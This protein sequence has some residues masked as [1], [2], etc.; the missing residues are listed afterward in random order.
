MVIKLTGVYLN[1]KWVPAIKLSDSKTKHTGDI[2]TIELCKKTL[3][4][5]E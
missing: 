1:K 5:G 3:E 2:E 4:I